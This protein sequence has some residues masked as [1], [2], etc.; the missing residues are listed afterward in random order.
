MAET[1]TN[2]HLLDCSRQTSEEYKS[3]DDTSPASWQNVVSGGLKLNAGDKVSIAYSSVNEIGCGNGQIE[4]KGKVIGNYDY[5]YGEVSGDLS[6][7][8]HG[9]WEYGPYATNYTTYDS[10]IKNKNVKD[11][12]FNIVLSYY[13]NTNGENYIHLPRRYDSKI[14]MNQ[15]VVADITG[16]T[17]GNGAEGWATGLR[18]R[19]KL[20]TQGDGVTNGRPHKIP[21]IRCFEDWHW[22]M[23]YKRY[24]P[25]SP[26]VEG[27]MA[28][29]TEGALDLTEGNE[30]TSCS[31]YWDDNRW[32]QKNDNSRY[33]IYFNSNQFWSYDELSG[34]QIAD[35]DEIQGDR[36]PAQQIYK[37]YKELKEYEITTGFN[38]PNNVAYQLTSQ[39]SDPVEG[40]TAQYLHQKDFDTTATT[41]EGVDSVRSVPNFPCPYTC[42][43]KGETYKPFPC[44]NFK[45]MSRGSVSTDV[46]YT[47]DTGFGSY[48]NYYNGLG[49][50]AQEGSTDLIKTRKC[51]NIVDYASS[52]NC[53][54]IKRPE[55]YDAGR[56]MMMNRTP[57]AV[58]QGYPLTSSQLGQCKGGIHGDVD[59]M[60]DWWQIDDVT[61]Q[62]S[63]FRYL[64]TKIPWNETNLQALSK[65]FKTQRL[66]GELLDFSKRD[67]T[68][69]LE[70]TS[71]L[72]AMDSP[73]LQTD[74]LSLEQDSIN[75]KLKNVYQKRFI[76]L[77]PY[78]EDDRNGGQFGS[79]M[80]DGEDNSAVYPAW[81]QTSG[82]ASM[83]VFF[84][85]NEDMEDT[86]LDNYDPNLNNTTS[87]EADDTEQL[88]Y[89]FAKKWKEVE[90]SYIMLNCRG[91][92]EELFDISGAPDV[93]VP[94]VNYWEGNYIGWD[95]HY[96]AYGNSAIM[97]YSGVMPDN[98]D[99]KQLVGENSQG[100][101][102]DGG[103]GVM[104]WRPNG[105]PTQIPQTTDAHEGR[106][107]QPHG[108]GI[109]Q[110]IRQIYIGA[111]DPIIQFVTANSRF[112]FAGLHTP[113]L[114]QNGNNAGSPLKEATADTDA[115]DVPTEAD[116][117][118]EVYKM[119]K[120]FT[121]WNNYTPELLP[122]RTEESYKAPYWEN[123]YVN[124]R[125]QGA[126][127]THSI[128]VGQV[129]GGF[130]E[131]SDTSGAV[132]TN[133]YL[134]GNMVHTGHNEYSTPSDVGANNFQSS[135]AGLT[136]KADIVGV[137]DGGARILDS[138]HKYD[139]VNL[140]ISPYIIYDSHS[141][142]FLEDFG[143][144]NERDWESSLFGIM[145]L[146]F[147]Q[148]NPTL[149]TQINRQA[150]LTRVNYN[151]VKPLTTCAMVPQK[152]LPT[153]VKNMWQKTMYSQQM[154][155][156]CV[157]S[158]WYGA[159][160]DYW[161]EGTSIAN[162][163]PT[164]GGGD[165]ATGGTALARRFF[166]L[167]DVNMPF[168]LPEVVNPQTSHSIMC[169]GLPIK[170]TSPY[171]LVK[172]DLL[173]DSYFLR[174]KTP[175]PIIAVINKE[176]L[177]GDYAF[178]QAGQMEYTI[179]QPK[180]ITSIRTEIYDADMTFASVGKSSAVIYKVTKQIPV[181][182]NLVAE[183]LNPM[184]Q[185]LKNT[186][187][188]SGPPYNPLAKPP[189]E[190]AFKP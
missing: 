171:Y 124:Q 152:D 129:R 73:P 2:I 167:G 92:P 135:N 190:S 12:E 35:F 13:K 19:T 32:K 128:A 70:Y 33:T 130:S 64:R 139:E 187:P 52:F 31:D 26:L 7:T 131:T 111:I 145:G 149:K 172:S 108:Y 61:P 156:N 98:I 43:S 160:G 88:C 79:D 78:V 5:N 77:D 80:A 158:L 75:G 180:I 45:T 181:N 179:T 142:I 95:F 51:R 94:P 102:T 170:M 96:N 49:L 25:Y 39:F 20:W 101:Q 50:T 122:W 118:T 47:S 147:K 121:M 71:S 41:G 34:G 137:D 182:P 74:L 93:Q 143:I 116:A 117:G 53:I 17:N 183:L 189:P 18:T 144:T 28:W 89:G 55:F 91:L 58:T 82:E 166:L 72:H 133:S 76:H 6:H 90:T 63:T 140:N 164:T 3:G 109:S 184:G 16:T 105:G 114:I 8:R 48:A 107:H 176:N 185:P 56:E 59:K 165:W 112:T 188:L 104:K 24:V 186:I 115:T 148:M 153:F 4:T 22:Y 113:E 159:V 37:P 174:N 127:Q 132:T 57:L 1:I 67:Q 10:K 173:A 69:N 150:K 87:L 65:F 86:Y 146:S 103:G 11:N 175:L 138:A 141:G 85:Y 126:A 110:L 60:I 84:Y 9:R 30:I 123:N 168:V 21:Y 15:P 36:D 81:I 38:D 119:N 154:P 66:Y 178:S 27:G 68:S 100:E 99:M 83:P 134:I 177:F 40:P 161:Y 29:K 151:Q 54:G 157:A 136:S 62:Y 155:A 23:G 120:R 42:S 97:L 169:D 163:P 162:I 14:D 125:P 46:G 44:A 106:P